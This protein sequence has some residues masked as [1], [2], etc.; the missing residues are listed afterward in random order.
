MERMKITAGLSNLNAYDAL[1]SAGADELFAGF[2]PFDW[3][4][5]YAN[6]LPLN[7][8]EVLM[9]NIQLD[10]FS[11]IRLLADKIEAQGV[12]VA[13]AFNSIHYLPE[14]YPL[15]LD[16]LDRLCTLGFQDWILA[17]P[18]LI[19]HIRQHG[20]PGRIH[21][22]GEAGCLN[23]DAMAFFSCFGIDR[24]IF[25]RKI[26]PEEMTDCIAAV[27][28]AQYEAF[29][30]NERCQYSGAHCASLHCDELEHL[31]RVPYQ[32]IGP[33]MRQ[34]APENEDADAF[35]AGG[36]GLCALP[37]LRKSG[38]THLKLVGRGARVEMLQ[39]DISMLRR[40]LDLGDV[41]E[42]TLR[43][44]LLKGKCSKNCYYPPSSAC[45]T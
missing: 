40:A 23:P 42:A 10:S 5:K 27:P 36:C 39:R 25:P 16:M 18:A 34:F 37:R 15:I 9:H 24:W 33:D 38:V 43:K 7:R 35:G 19:L 45:Q 41:D 29:L 4:E 30:L 11:E 8:R 6:L 28:G 12:P 17:D 20:L 22:S 1:V 32:I 26:T 2:L 13:L 3:L 14:Q 31:C 44:E 21:L